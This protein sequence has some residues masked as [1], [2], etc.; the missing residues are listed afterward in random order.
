MHKRMGEVQ[1]VE[2]GLAG[3]CRGPIKIYT[4]DADL[5]STPNRRDNRSKQVE[6][7]WPQLEAVHA[8]RRNDLLVA[9]SGGPGKFRYIQ[10]LVGTQ[11]AHDDARISATDLKLTM[12]CQCGAELARPASEYVG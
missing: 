9:S 2:S 11:Y 6:S 5:A 7:E 4:A 10:D 1:R 8:L 12:V 3:S